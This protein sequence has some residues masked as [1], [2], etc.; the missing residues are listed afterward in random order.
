[1][2][3]KKQDPEA[4]AR[5]I[6]VEIGNRRKAGEVIPD[7]QVLRDHPK[8]R[9]PLLE[10]LERLSRLE[11]ARAQ[12]EQSDGAPAVPSEVICTDHQGTL[13]LPLFG[14]EA[15]SALSEPQ[16]AHEAAP[17]AARFGNSPVAS[18]ARATQLKATS[19]SPEE[20]LAEAE[21]PGTDAPGDGN[22][23][24]ITLKEPSADSGQQSTLVVGDAGLPD[25]ASGR[26]AIARY[27]PTVRPPMAVVKLFHDGQTTFNQYPI[28]S[29]RF[30]IG[31]L[32]GDLVVPH[33]FWM[34][35]RHAEIQ[36]HKRGDSYHWMLVD[37]NSTNGTFVQTDSA[38]LRHND[39]LFLGQERYRFILQNNQASLM[40]VTRGA[41]QQWLIAETPAHIG[42][43]LPCGL[44]IFASDLYLDPVHAYI[45]RE[46]DGSWIIRDNRSQN[47]VWFRTKEIELLANAEF[48]L[49]EQRFG[50]WTEADAAADLSRGPSGTG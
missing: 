50:F 38:I 30:R 20:P 27:R 8:L 19:S 17:Q 21:L 24:R 48:Q 11:A 9:Q 37:L 28:F 29:D 4:Q 10:Q 46:P 5:Q 36:R 13:D 31:R 34:S 3:I 43:Q 23:L 12:A 1:M 39:E 47:G 2:P 49:G 40:H 33:D 15:D 44:K 25:S 14:E 26:S 41:G 42:S 45:F 6:A 18:D 35:G 22:Q 7:D 16:S 32:D